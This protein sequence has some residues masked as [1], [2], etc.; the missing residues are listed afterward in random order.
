[1]SGE[2]E[3]QRH[4]TFDG[5]GL[6]ARRY[7]TRIKVG[8]NKTTCPHMWRGCP[9]RYWS[10]LLTIDDEITDKLHTRNGGTL[11]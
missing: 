10:D 8:S 2:F 3:N 6:K 4:A 9:S 11:Y 5:I 7:K 1:M